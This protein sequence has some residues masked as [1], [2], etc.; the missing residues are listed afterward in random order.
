MSKL[1]QMGEK[2][3]DFSLPIGDGNMEVTDSNTF[4]LSDKKGKNIILAFYPADWSSVCS[5]QIALYSQLQPE[6]SEF[7]A[8]V[9]GIS[10]DGTYCHRAFKENHNMS[11]PLLCD[12]EPKGELSKLYGVYNEKLGLS[13]R[14]IYVIDKEGIVQF[15]YIS[16]MGENPGAKEILETLKKI[17]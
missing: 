4:K 2:A 15:S 14:A 13:E 5:S 1:I 3:P 7:N 12:F 8:E 17:S 16:P 6:F 10:V 11:I 9:Y